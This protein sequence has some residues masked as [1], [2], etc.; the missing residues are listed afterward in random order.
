MDIEVEGKL[1]HAA[2]GG[3]QG[4]ANEPAVVFI[5]GAG[6]DHTAWQLQARNVAHNG[7]RVFAVDLPG[8]G[9][10]QGSAL[11]S[12]AKMADWVAQFMNASGIG[13]A[14]I[15]GHS[16]GALVALEI[17]ARHSSQVNNLLL[18]GV[19]ETM[20]VHPDLLAAAEAN[21]PLGPEL[22]VFWGLSSEAQIGGHLQPGLWVHGASEILLKSSK[23]G[24]LGNDLA[25][26][27]K[28]Q[29]GLDAAKT[30]SC[31]AKLILG[32]DDKM[33]PVK[34][35]VALSDVMVEVSIDIIP[36]CGHMIML[37]RPE[38]VYKSM[39]DFVF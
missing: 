8:H 2:T 34:K 24:V 17:G 9:R 4:N 15:I 39:K 33:T 13:P 14:T 7:R 3:R 28:Y 31:P 22:I 25:A 36:N 29:D 20:P 18:I 23:S 26:S 27:N 6:M 16:M 32:A 38:E 12:I 19:A 5:H 35:G 30:I 21:Q 11:K 1:A 10:S 37:E